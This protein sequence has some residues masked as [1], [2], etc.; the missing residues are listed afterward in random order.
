[1]NGD[2][3]LVNIGKLASD[4]DVRSMLVELG[5][6]AEAPPIRDGF[7]TDREAPASGTAVFFRTAGSLNHI[8][9][10]AAL[11]PDT[12]V[13]SDIKFYK[14]GFGGGPAYSKGL[15][16]GL[17][18]E[19]TRSSVHARFGPPSRAALVGVTDTW[20]SDG[21]YFSV[22]FDDETQTVER[23]SAGFE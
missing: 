14:A 9:R 19:E 18:W 5:L 7:M 4:P 20:T 16:R 17:T 1:M 12:P 2:D 13:F 22:G 21:R 15:P 3:F 23:A 8:A 10:F 11:P 6:P